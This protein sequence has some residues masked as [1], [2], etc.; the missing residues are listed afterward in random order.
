MEYL[1]FVYNDKSK[2]GIDMSTTLYQ[3][4]NNM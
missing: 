3:I 4:E 2:I 1:S